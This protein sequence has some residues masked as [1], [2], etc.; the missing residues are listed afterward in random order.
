[1][2]H[3]IKV[4]S[5]NHFLCQQQRSLKILT[6][7]LP[8]HF[9]DNALGMHS[10]IVKGIC[11][12]VIWKVST[13]LWISHTAAPPCP[14]GSTLATEARCVPTVVESPFSFP[15]DSALSTPN[16]H[17]WDPDSHLISLLGHGKSARLRNQE[18][19]YSP[20]TLHF[21]IPNTL[22]FRLAVVKKGLIYTKCQWRTPHW[23]QIQ[24]ATD[25]PRLWNDDQ[26]LG[27]STAS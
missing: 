14:P 27:A 8:G 25:Y 2:K 13:S 16:T 24:L 23:I 5:S 19:L 17:L 12:G 7:H 1:M 22:A 3:A 20:L 11:L 9:G 6:P 18:K 10:G 26:W 21:S 15:G 4:S